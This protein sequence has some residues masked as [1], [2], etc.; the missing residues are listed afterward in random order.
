MFLVRLIDVFVG[1][2]EFVFRPEKRGQGSSPATL[3]GLGIV[4]LVVLV[5]L[6]IGIPQLTYRT[7]TSPYAAEL[8]NAEG[9]TTNDPV[10]V[11]GVPAGR[12]EAIRLAGDRVRV[13]FRLD[14]DQPLG[15]QTRAGVRLR[16]VLG[17]RYLNVIPAGHGSVGADN[18]IPLSRTDTSFTL[19]DFSA[20]A[21]DSSATIDPTVIRSM[22]ST[23]KSIVPDSDDLSAALSGAGGAAL[24]I[25]GTGR[26]LD[27][28]LTIARTLA[29]V[30]SRQAQTVSSAFADTQNI[31]QTLV[32]RKVV[33]T[34]LADNL[35]LVLGTMAQTFPQVPMGELTRNVVSVTDTLKRNS[36]NID[37]ILVNLPPAMRTIVDSTGNGN[38]ADVVS[39][40]A[41]IPDGLLCVL[42]VM[43]GC[44]A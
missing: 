29:D 7:S 28:L 5:V 13:E 40:S 22:M 6:A 10:L 38:W 20:A 24:A 18:T 23:M 31:V 44:S 27:Q 39:P 9:L 1:I 34:R 37:Q 33:M 41:V 12:I 19:D 26:Q 35:R 14:D 17:K 25:S 16:T 21:V 3:G 15:G 32:V 11:A 30:T 42:G 8:A 2:I 43:Q 36:A 4:T